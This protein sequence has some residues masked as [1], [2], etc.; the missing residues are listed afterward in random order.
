MSDEL[1][2]RL[3]TSQKKEEETDLGSEM[4]SFFK[5]F[6]QEGGMQF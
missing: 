1:Q 6:L 3:G 5:N 2:G 4:S